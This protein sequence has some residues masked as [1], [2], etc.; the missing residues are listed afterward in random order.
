MNIGPYEGPRKCTECGSRGP[1]LRELE[2]RWPGHN[3]QEIDGYYSTIILCPGCAPTLQHVLKN[4]FSRP[5][6]KNQRA[7]GA[8]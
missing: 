3:S 5:H 7:A 8:R 2:F 1:G 4:E 6:L